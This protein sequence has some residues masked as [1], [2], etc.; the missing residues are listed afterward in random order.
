MV[1]GT[2]GAIAALDLVVM[3]DTKGAQIVYEPAPVV[4]AGRARQY[5]AIRPTLARIFATL[6]LNQLQASTPR[7]RSRARQPREVAARLPRA[8]G[9]LR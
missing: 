1:Y 5:P 4:R 8:E 2:D 7:S 9:L 6:T 3:E